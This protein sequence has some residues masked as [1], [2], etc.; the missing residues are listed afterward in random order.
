MKNYQKIFDEALE[1]FPYELE[2]TSYT[3]GNYENDEYSEEYIF[4]IGKLLNKSLVAGGWFDF[5]NDEG[6]L[7]ISAS[8]GVSIDGDFKDG[9]IF[10]ENTAIQCYYDLEEK[11]WEI[12][13]GI[14]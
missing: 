3:M 9:L 14:Y 12:E 6:E 7:S 8:F 2:P 5:R 10:P 11:T 1:K 4:E 13:I